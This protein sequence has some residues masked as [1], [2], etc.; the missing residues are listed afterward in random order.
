MKIAI[1]GYGL[2]GESNYRYW[3]NSAENDITIVDQRQP[4]RTIPNGVATIIGEDAF[5]KLQD[6]DLVI[7]TAGLAPSK[8]KTK[9]KI[10]SATNEFF[11]KCPALIIGVTGSK[12]KGTTASLITNILRESGKKV[13]LIGNIGESSLDVLN[14]IDKNDIVVYELSSFQLWDLEKSPHIAVILFIEREHQDIHSSIE[15]YVQAKSNVTKYQTANDVLIY[16]QFN[17]YA[18]GIASDSKARLLGYTDEKTAHVKE[19]YFYYSEQKI[20]SIDALQV[21]G[22]HNQDN[23]CA[24]IDVIWELI[25]DKG[26]IERGISSFK[27]LPHRLQFIREINGVKYYD[28]SIATTPSSAI[29]A[30]KSFDGPKVIILGGSSK[31]S[32]FS[33]LGSELTRHDVKAIL[34]GDEAE[35]IAKACQNAGFSDF[36]I[37]ENPTMTKVVNRAQSLVKPGGVVLLSPASASFGLFKNYVDRGEQFE[38]AVYAI[39]S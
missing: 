21:I 22:K 13:W 10:W 5:E 4:D 24:A 8:I 38:A 35:T 23:A 16:N 29:A 9:G 7:R 14:Q 19:G 31:G 28:D 27:G 36:E 6:F 20:C 30:L 32:D 15:E 2:E 34:I 1:A 3:V 12:G 11:A 39:T 25:Q 18:K 26:A 37:M 33:E 17:Q